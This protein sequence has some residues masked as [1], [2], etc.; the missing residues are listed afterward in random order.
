MATPRITT[1]PHIVRVPGVVGGE[2]VIAGTRVPVRSVV[3][4][5]RIYGSMDELHL[6]FPHVP[7]AELEEALAYYDAHQEEIE[8]Y[9]AENQDWE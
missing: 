8:Q 7:V 9:I 2:P 1:F 4:Y 6:T 3:L 5:F